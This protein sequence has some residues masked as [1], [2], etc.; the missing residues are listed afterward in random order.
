MY[1]YPQLSRV[2]RLWSCD[3]SSVTDLQLLNLA[4]GRQTQPAPAGVWYRSY[5][6]SYETARP[7]PRKTCIRD[8]EAC[9]DFHI[10][11]TVRHRPSRRARAV[12]MERE[13][14]MSYECGW[15]TGLN[16]HVH[17]LHLG[18]DCYAEQDTQSRLI[19]GP[20]MHRSSLSRCVMNNTSIY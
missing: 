2:S 18:V 16:I 5:F 4:V 15:T 12:M 9:N 7:P 10:W 1:L 13:R 3:P 20:Q 8:W 17:R 19:K 14:F 11:C 6:E